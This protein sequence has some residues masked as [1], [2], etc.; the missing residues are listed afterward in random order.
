MNFFKLILVFSLIWLVLISGCTTTVSPENTTPNSN[1]PNNLNVPNES[2]SDVNSDSVSYNTLG[3][4][5]D[6]DIVYDLNWGVVFS[7]VQNKEFD[8]ERF[9]WN[10]PEYF[11]GILFLSL[12]EWDLELI[13]IK[14]VKLIDALMGVNELKSLNEDYNFVAMFF[15]YQESIDTNESLPNFDTEYIVPV[16]GTDINRDVSYWDYFDDKGNK[17][18]GVF[19]DLKISGPILK[20]ANKPKCISFSMDLN[21]SSKL[22]KIPHDLYLDDV[23]IQRNNSFGFSKGPECLAGVR[24]DLNTRDVCTCFNQVGLDI[25]GHKVGVVIDPENIYHEKEERNN[26]LENYV[27]DINVNF[28]FDGNFDLFY[29]SNYNGLGPAFYF[30]HFISAGLCDFEECRI[31]PFILDVAFFEGDKRIETKKSA[32]CDKKTELTEKKDYTEYYLNYCSDGK[33]FLLKKLL[34]LG[35]HKIEF[36]LNPN[37]EISESNFKDNIFKKTFE[38]K[39][40]N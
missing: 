7:T 29:T 25:S 28:Y 24:T 1:N 16:N 36:V 19:G 14:S 30:E 26:F 18:E 11:K 15:N 23:L 32:Y 37:N 10:E 33:V 21:L 4:A 34:S 40:N 17:V 35:E 12:N 22:T 38:V 31:Q 2:N 13:D 27:Q 9:L 39:I 6:Y 5:I 3:G 20:F 8:I